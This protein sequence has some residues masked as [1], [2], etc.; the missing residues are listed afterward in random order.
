MVSAIVDNALPLWLS[1]GAT[2]EEFGAT[3]TELQDGLAVSS[4]DAGT[5]EAEM[6]DFLKTA[7]ASGQP[8]Q[9]SGENL[10]QFFIRLIQGRPEAFRV[11]VEARRRVGGPQTTTRFAKNF[12]AYL[13]AFLKEKPEPRL[14]VAPS[15]QI[16]VAAPPAAPST[17]ETVRA[18]PTEM[19]YTT[20]F[21]LV[22]ILHRAAH[23]VRGGGRLE[24][25]DAEFKAAVNRY[26]N[27][28]YYLEGRTVPRF[29]KHIGEEIWYFLAESWDR[30]DFVTVATVLLREAGL[31]PREVVEQLAPLKETARGIPDETDNAMARGWQ[32]YDSLSSMHTV[33]TA[34]IAFVG[35]VA[36]EAIRG[37][38]D[39]E[40][41]V[42]EMAQALK[43]AISDPMTS[44]DAG[45]IL[46]M[47]TSEIEDTRILGAVLRVTMEGV[48]SPSKRGIIF[49]TAMTGIIRDDEWEKMV[50]KSAEQ[51]VLFGSGGYEEAEAYSPPFAIIEREVRMGSGLAVDVAERHSHR[52]PDWFPYENP[53]N[54]GR[55]VL[56]PK[57]AEELRR[58]A[59]DPGLPMEGKVA[60]F[61]SEMSR[62]NLPSRFGV[63][64]IFALIAEEKGISD[65]DLGTLISHVMIDIKKWDKFDLTPPDE[66][67]K[68]IAMMAGNGRSIVQILE[69]VFKWIH[70]FPRIYRGI[71]LRHALA[72]INDFET[73]ADS[74]MIVVK[75]MREEHSY[76]GEP[77]YTFDY[78]KPKGE[79][80]NLFFDGSHPSFREKVIAAIKARIVRLFPERSFQSGSGE[81][82]W[83]INY[84]TESW[85]RYLERS[86]EPV[87]TGDSREWLWLHY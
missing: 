76:G 44:E 23:F 29:T 16:K 50:L 83:Q 48:E 33:K 31:N 6:A 73:I 26:F 43:A 19:D 42:G 51:Q 37:L 61:R 59:M 79:I 70:F 32:E 45:I 4:F 25:M 11:I 57:L 82:E 10:R 2:A 69:P 63:G 65:A 1:P 9:L 52:L 66:V 7:F 49:R 72:G 67:G 77:Y 14:T 74:L 20:R 86:L 12:P 81:R 27:K 22:T 71:V 75:Q 68:V 58:V 35:M 41:S 18:S 24:N 17:A 47:A 38:E 39:K 78:D 36:R 56:L 15:I 87:K 60:I 84:K 40:G 64:R 85:D 5:P 13:A 62:I 34:Q 8:L 55:G 54:T 3:V 30:S 53:L 28:P 46:R 21:P 80:L